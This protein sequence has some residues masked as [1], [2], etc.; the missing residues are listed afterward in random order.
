MR[1]ETRWKPDGWEAS[2][3]IGVLTPHADINPESELNAM[4]PPSVAIHATRVPFGAMAAGG[5]MDPT[6]PW[7][8]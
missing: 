3:R 5:T 6:I 8:P 4:A 7:S 1:Q 2:V